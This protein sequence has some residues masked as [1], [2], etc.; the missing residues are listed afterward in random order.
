M[1]LGK[2]FS[3]PITEEV[4]PELAQPLLMLTFRDSLGKIQVHGGLKV[5]TFLG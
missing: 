4:G 5:D 2:F 3:L 1:T